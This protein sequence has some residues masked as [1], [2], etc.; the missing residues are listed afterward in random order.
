MRHV[1]K[2]ENKLQN[3]SQFSSE[4]E[5]MKENGTEN[6]SSTDDLYSKGINRNS[7][8]GQNIE[9]VSMIFEDAGLESFLHDS[10]IENNAFLDILYNVS[11]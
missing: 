5:S 8:N 10:K 11:D 7:K 6:Y 2:E 9:K 3:N 4:D 1:A